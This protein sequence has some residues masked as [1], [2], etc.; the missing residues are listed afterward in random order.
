[1]KWQEVE[2]QC[3]VALLAISTWAGDFLLPGV[4]WYFAALYCLFRVHKCVWAQPADAFICVPV[5][6]LYKKNFSLLEV[7]AL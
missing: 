4:V 1:M 3:P 2:G 5:I 6:C 7:I